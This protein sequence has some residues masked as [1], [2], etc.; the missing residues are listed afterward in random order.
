MERPLDKT[1][2]RKFIDNRCTPEELVRV[3]TFLQQ[4][5][6]E[7][8]LEEMLNERWTEIPDEPAETT[9]L[10]AWQATFRQ[11][12]TTPKPLPAKRFKL[13]P[14]FKYAAAVLL[15]ATV[16]GYGW[17]HFNKKQAPMAI[18]MLESTTKAGKLLKVV[19]PDST[20][21]YLNA[22]SRLQY[23]EQF[24]GDARTVSLQ[25]EAFFDVKQD[26]RHPFFV[27]TDELQVQVLG[28]SFNVRSYKD[29]E[30]IAV[31][32]ATGKVGV[33]IPGGNTPG[34]ILLPDQELTYARKSG[35]VQVAATIAANSHAWEKGAFVFNYETLENITKRLSRWYGITV[36]CAN[37]ALLQQ[38]Y[39]LKIRNEKLHNVLQAL[40]TSGKG[41][42]YEIRGNTVVIK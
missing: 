11:K 2:L 14:M 24:T 17:Y 1:L 13:M 41:F 10:E 42:R 27:K 6:A 29:D 20:I 31:T 8:L 5:E 16:G 7:Q 32:V 22:E 18:A 38:R 33:T 12:I 36:S 3:R 23:P 40:S 19:L 9:Q 37:P 30:A 39:K 4:P 15:I 28:T 25:G 21:V 34:S 26:D 35:Q